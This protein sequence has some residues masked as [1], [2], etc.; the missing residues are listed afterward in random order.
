MFSKNKK[1]SGRQVFRLLT[2]DILGLSTLLVPTVLGRTAGRDGI[3]CIFLGVFAVLLYL[4]VIGFVLEDIKGDYPEYLQQEFGSFFGLLVQLG[5]FLYLA[6][7]AG[8]TAY[9]FAGV[10]INSLLREVSFFSVLFVI[11]LLAAYGLWGGIEGRARVYEILFWFLMIPLFFMLFCALNEVETDYWTPIFFSEIES[12]GSGTYYVFQS[13]SVVFLVLFL[14]KHVE[15]KK[16]LLVAAKS[17]IL[18]TGGVHAV[19][20][21]ILLGIFGADA[22]GTMDFPAVTLMSTIKI[23]GGFFKR[24]DAF[25]FGIWFFTLYALLAGSVFYAGSILK[26]LVL[27]RVHDLAKKEETVERIASCI[28]LAAVFLIAGLFYKNGENTELYEMFL[29]Y[30]GTPFVTAVPVVLAVKKWICK[31][32]GNNQGKNKKHVLWLS[33]I[34]LPFF[35]C[36]GCTAPELEERNFPIEAAIDSTKDFSSIW[37]NVEKQGNRVIDY[38]HLKVLILGQEFLEDSDAMSELLDLLEKKSSVP[39]NTYIVA[40]ENAKDIIGLSEKLGESVGNYLEQM[41]ENVSGIKK[42]SCPTLGMLY[43][44]QENHLETLFIPYIVEQNEKPVVGSYY[45]WKRGEAAGNVDN[46]AA[47]LSF[48]TDNHME[49]YTV[50][51]P[52]G[53]DV[54]LFSPHNELFFYEDNGKKIVVKVRC[55]GEVLYAEEEQGLSDLERHIEDGMNVAAAAILHEQGIDLTNSYRK[56]G[57]YKREWYER[58]QRQPGRYEEE[59]EIIYDVR[60]EWATIT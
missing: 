50:S 46:G 32:F 58:Y 28:V 29:L 31:G 42:Q 26:H 20:Y 3:F 27:L 35:F 49:E 12:I 41:F 18:F 15:K 11:V 24:A 13:L 17:A 8:Y 37:L 55:M 2:Y 9:L 16:T 39:R 59:I 53:T 30:I 25:M 21:I 23:T 6:L 33:V 1:I 22:L 10:V 40:A 44:E 52:I 36:S 51:L 60:I 14:Q 34:L 45:V 19:L 7:L 57:G 5:Y 47:L 38:S 54:R 48:F 43:Q 4:A 56:I